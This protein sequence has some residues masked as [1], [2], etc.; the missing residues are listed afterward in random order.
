MCV[1]VCACVILH[2]C[3]CKNKVTTPELESPRWRPLLLPR[4]LRWRT[5]SKGVRIDVLKSAWDIVFCTAEHIHTYILTYIHLLTHDGGPGRFWSSGAETIINTY[6]SNR[7]PAQKKTHIIQIVLY[8]TMT[9]VI[10]YTYFDVGSAVV[11]ADNNKASSCI[12]TKHRLGSLKFTLLSVR[13]VYP[14]LSFL[15]CQ[16]H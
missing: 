2:V 16:F 9:K 4:D 10:Q 15:C 6:H 12:D 1:H 3:D 7:T 13:T 8:D 11:I 5:N 14:D